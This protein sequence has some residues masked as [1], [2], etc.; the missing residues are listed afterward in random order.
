MRDRYWD[1]GTLFDVN[2]QPA[3]MSVNNLETG[4]QWLFGEIYN[5]REL[6]RRQRHYMDIYKNSLAVAT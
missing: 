2:F 4:L 3:R 5:D 6:A 1:R